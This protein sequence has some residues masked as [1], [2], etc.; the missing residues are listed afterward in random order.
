MLFGGLER[1]LGARSRIRY[2]QEKSARC[3]SAKSVKSVAQNAVNTRLHSYGFRGFRGNNQTAVCGVCRSLRPRANKPLLR[4]FVEIGSSTKTSSAR[5]CRCRAVLAGR[6]IAV[7]H[8]DRQL[9][10]RR[11]GRDARQC[12]KTSGCTHA[13]RSRWVGHNHSRRRVPPQ[14]YFLLWRR[15]STSRSYEC[16][17][18]R[19]PS[20]RSP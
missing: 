8:K 12:E 1:I 14:A 15:Q 17:P 10:A 5:S 7:S 3:F 19:P 6:S 9:S 16:S 18:I 20:P 11:H 2:G 4:V 13:D